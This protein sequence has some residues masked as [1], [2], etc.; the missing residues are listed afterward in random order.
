[1]WKVR[2]MKGEG[3]VSKRAGTSFVG[4]VELQS[5]KWKQVESVASRKRS[6]VNFFLVW[7]WTFW[8][9][10]FVYKFFMMRHKWF[11]LAESFLKRRNTFPVIKPFFEL[12]GWRMRSVYILLYFKP[13]LNVQTFT[14]WCSFVYTYFKPTGNVRTYVNLRWDISLINQ[15][16]SANCF[17]N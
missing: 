9:R 15:H 10:L 17:L 14:N 8:K 13:T 7:K 4:S 3:G 16:F 1:M 5:E 11:F 2:S 6:F 12:K